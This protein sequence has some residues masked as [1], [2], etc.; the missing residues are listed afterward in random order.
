MPSIAANTLVTAPVGPNGTGLT[1]LV[2]SVDG[3]GNATYTWSMS[4]TPHT[5]TAPIST[6][7]YVAPFVPQTDPIDLIN[8]TITALTA[9]IAVLEAKAGVTPPGA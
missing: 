4:G 7:T 2:T 8:S 1:V 6:L 9:R 3:A 5:Q